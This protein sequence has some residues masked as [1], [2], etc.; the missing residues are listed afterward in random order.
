MCELLWSEAMGSE[1]GLSIPDHCDDGPSTSLKPILRGRDQLHAGVI[2]A[3]FVVVVSVFYVASQY[4]N[5]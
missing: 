2:I 3:F 5:S 4:H 1:Y